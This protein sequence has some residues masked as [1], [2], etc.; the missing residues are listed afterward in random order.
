MK[1]GPQL[2]HVAADFGGKEGG[3]EPLN[4]SQDTLKHV[5]HLLKHLRPLERVL[6]L[7]FL[8]KEGEKENEGAAE[9]QEGKRQGNHGTKVSKFSWKEEEKPP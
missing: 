1:F 2:T 4:Y 9:G 8:T 6:S 7:H 5:T 3:Q